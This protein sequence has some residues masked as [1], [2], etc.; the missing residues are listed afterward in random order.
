MTRRARPPVFNAELSP[1]EREVL[2]LL[3][4]PMTWAEIAVRLGVSKNTIKTH[5]GAIYR[6]LG[7]SSR[8]EA[9]AAARRLGYIS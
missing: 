9:V 2:A 3:A 4:T 5:T 7:A 8:R 1:R 6:K